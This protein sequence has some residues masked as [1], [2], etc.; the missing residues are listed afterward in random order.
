M[1]D[2]SNII[3]H[4]IEVHSN[5]V[6]TI[7]EVEIQNASGNYNTALNKLH[8]I[9]LKINIRKKVKKKKSTTEIKENENQFP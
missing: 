3:N 7:K 8:T 1:K 2:K 6:D 5:H 4:L 9:G